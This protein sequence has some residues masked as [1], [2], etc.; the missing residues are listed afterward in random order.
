MACPHFDF[1][2]HTHY[3]GCANETM[4]VPEIVAECERV[5]VEKLALTDHLNT[6][7]KAEL[8]RPILEDI[9]RLE[10]DVEVYYGVELNFMDRDG[11]FAYG[12]RVRDRLGFQFA[13]GGIHQSYL[14]TFDLDKIVDIQHRH[15]LR[16]CDDPLVSV[17][18]HPYW[19]GLADYDKPGWPSFF[20]VGQ[21]PEARV[22]ELGQAAKATGT[23]IEINAYANLCEWPTEFVR[24]YEGFLAMLA[25]EG[26]LFSVS[27]DSH[28]ITHL[29]G[30]TEAWAMADRIGLSPERIWRPDCAPIVG[31]KDKAR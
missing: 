22:R 30:V 16:V 25:E 8:H 12:E 20:P 10:T 28:K 3:L 18:V 13:I 4:T 29:Q 17:L 27:S 6:P 26:P 31:G 2:I 19:F 9:R 1:H 24:Q 23:A 7:D 14:P 21:V 11:Y 15:H 5:G